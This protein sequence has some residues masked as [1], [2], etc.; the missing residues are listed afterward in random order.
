MRGAG[1]GA[2]ATPG[3]ESGKGLLGPASWWLS[4][5]SGA[6]LVPVSRVCAVGA[7]CQ[8]KGD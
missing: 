2:L 6:S 5:P 4:L 7:R 3:P 8:H 1:A